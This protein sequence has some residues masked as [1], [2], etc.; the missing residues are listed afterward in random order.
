[1]TTKELIKSLKKECKQLDSVPQKL[2]DQN[3]CR[4]TDDCGCKMFHNPGYIGESNYPDYNDFSSD[5]FWYIHDIPMCIE[6]VAK[7]N[8]WPITPFTRAG[9]QE[10]MR[11]VIKLIEDEKI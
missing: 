6:V 5:M 1:M 2:Y 10:R 7:R 4:P 9:C 3:T 11:F 8:N